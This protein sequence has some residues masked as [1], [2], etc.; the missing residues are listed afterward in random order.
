MNKSVVRSRPPLSCHSVASRIPAT[1]SAGLDRGEGKASHSRAAAII[2]L[3]QIVSL[4][5]LFAGDEE[6][7]AKNLGAARGA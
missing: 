3:A 2:T 7:T 4:T 1:A 6:L 5:I